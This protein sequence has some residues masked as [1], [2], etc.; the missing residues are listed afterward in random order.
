[1]RAVSELAVPFSVSVQADNGAV[2]A[3]IAGDL[4]LAT[5][6]AVK[7]N[8]RPF[9]D[10]G[11]RVVY[12]LEQVDFID[13]SGLESLFEAVENDESI[14]FRNPSWSVRRIVELLDISVRV[15][16]TAL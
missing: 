8:L 5:G 2:I 4:D 14:V 13:S 10:R 12:E 1:M 3:A 6:P 7:D 11:V 9:L 15:E 16:E